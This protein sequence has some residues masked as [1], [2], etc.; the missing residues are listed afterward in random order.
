[1]SSQSDRLARDGK[2]L[3][4]RPHLD[5]VHQFVRA[6]LGSFVLD[7]LNGQINPTE[8]EVNEVRVGGVVSEEDCVR[9][10]SRSGG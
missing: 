1:M 4:L 8:S 5:G 2:N 3:V 6:F 10:D 7:F 9:G